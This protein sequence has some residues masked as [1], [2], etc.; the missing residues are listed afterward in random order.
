MDI[1]L[2]GLSA[3]MA[4]MRQGNFDRAAQSL[5]ITPSAI[6]QRLK[7][8]EEKLG[9]T[10]VVRSLPVRP[11]PA[12]AALLKYGQ[13]LEQL[14]HILEHDLQ[15]TNQQG[16][17][18]MAI[19]V[20]ADTLATWL[21]ECL[22]PWCKAQRVVLDIRVDDQDQT[23][24]LL[25]QG[26]VV[27]CMSA[28]EKVSQGCR[29][30]PL[31]KVRYQCMVSP[32]FYSEYFP[33]GVTRETLLKAPMVRFNLKDDL[34][35]AYLR[36][37][38]ELDGENLVQHTLPSAESFVQGLILGMGFGM[39]PEIQVQKQLE[40]GQLIYLTPELPLDIPLFWHQW[41]I[42]TEL[43]RSLNSVI[44]AGAKQVHYLN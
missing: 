14:G 22:A 2:K 13:Q 3:F 41:G 36:Q 31:G 35:H 1:D 23:H 18:K 25:Q 27:A 33:T 7:L 40:K 24:H 42:E 37:H 17:L 30:I 39:A 5:F 12:G 26:E 9:Q 44:L 15:P 29:C 16:W 38:F 32:D 19:A 4:I 10:L 6:S 21:L 34:Q 11:T 43:M 20:N 8:L 28:R